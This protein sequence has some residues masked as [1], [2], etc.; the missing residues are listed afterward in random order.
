MQR[1]DTIDF[2]KGVTI[3]LVVLGHVITQQNYFIAIFGPMQMP[4]FMFLFG[5]LAG[6]YQKIQQ[7]DILKK[8][9]ARLILPL[10]TA[11]VLY[12]VFYN[13]FSFK[14]DAVARIILIPGERWFLYALSAYLLVFFITAK[15]RAWKPAL[16][17]S[18]VLV[19]VCWLVPYGWP[20][21]PTRIMRWF[22][23]AI[24]GFMYAN[25]VMHIK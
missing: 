14:I 25:N 9:Y 20:M 24:T 3:I 22:L 10:L 1:N 17:T 13:Q 4:I 21:D 23:Y 2:V 6:N 8:K 18:V 15:S 7:K 11:T 19:L 5:Y 12:Y 16:L